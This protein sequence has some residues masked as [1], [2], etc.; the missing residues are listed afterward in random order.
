MLRA[1]AFI[2]LFIQICPPLVFMRIRV[3][4]PLGVCM[5]ASTYVQMD[6]N[7]YV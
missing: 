3:H 5:H 6:V 2:H 1:H 7:L 4:V